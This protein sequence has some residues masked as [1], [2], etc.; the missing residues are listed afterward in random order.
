MSSLL[1]GIWSD[2]RVSLHGR[3]QL[4][5]LELQQAGHALLQIVILAVAAG[6]LVCGAWLTLMV[7]VFM[8]TVQAGL[9]WG[10]A[11]AIIFF[12]NVGMAFGMWSVAFRLTRHLTLPATVRSLSSGLK[13]DR[14]A[15]AQASGPGQT[16]EP[17]A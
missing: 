9:H 17:H 8:G 12:V 16:G 14:T 2:L 11:I 6:V 10:V 5:S 15:D 3:L 13:P 7:A 4:M 1:G